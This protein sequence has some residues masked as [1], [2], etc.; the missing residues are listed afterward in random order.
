MT[1]RTSRDFS[2]ASARDTNPTICSL[3]D[4]SLLATDEESG[5][6]KRGSTRTRATSIGT[7]VA[8]SVAFIK[9]P[10]VE[11]VAERTSVASATR[12]VGSGLESTLD[13]E[14]E[15]IESSA[16]AFHCPE[17]VGAIFAGSAGA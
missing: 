14:S 16:G 11:I 2:S 5:D 13:R 17:P 12:M 10:I 7:N 3:Y 15:T 6:S 9:C 8:T 4:G 1:S